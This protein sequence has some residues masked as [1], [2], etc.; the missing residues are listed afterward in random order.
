MA[1]RGDNHCGETAEEFLAD[2][3]K[4]LVGGMIGIV[5]AIGM[6][7]G[8]F[9]VL[10]SLGGEPKT[11][12]EIADAGNFKERYVREWLGA[13]TAARV[14]NFDPEEEK[15]WLPVH[16]S[17]ITELRG[18]AMSAP[19]LCGG[20]LQVVGC[21]QK[22][23]PPG[24]PFSQYPRFD[25]LMT[26][27]QGPWFHTK[28]IQEFIPSMPQIQKQLDE[29][30]EVLDAGCGAGLS[31]RILAGHFPKS[32]FCGV[33]LSESAILEVKET[34]KETGLTNVEFLASDISRLPTDWTERFHFVFISFVLHDL[35][36]PAQV[37]LEMYRVLR[38]GGTLS[39]IEVNSHS[40][41][42]DNLA[43]EDRDRIC[44]DYTYS[45][46]NC[47]PTSLVQGDGAGLGAFLGREEAQKMLE[48]AN[49]EVVA[50]TEIATE[51]MH[52]MCKKP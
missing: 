9:D 37:L 17:N 14:V 23:G 39:I 15:Y 5:V 33:D 51:S 24:V 10:I 44:L 34:A 2:M 1:N 28:M 11:S 27:T 45:V 22:D 18:L 36:Y 46:L 16:R 4:K 20:F 43:F 47:L 12:V 30:I 7:T 19:I 32:R 49:F 35:S 41:L 8:L 31:T 29:G 25:E 13:M 42:K 52:I 6:E 50:I 21:F 3:E 48:T 38:P 40:K 26:V